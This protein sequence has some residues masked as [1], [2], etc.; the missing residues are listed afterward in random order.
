MSEM[1]DGLNVLFEDSVRR[2]RGTANTIENDCVIPVVQAATRF[3][4]AN[5]VIFTFLAFFGFFSAIPFL[6]A[7]AISTFA[8]TIL[9]A[10]LLGIFAFFTTGMLL[11][12]GV[13]LTPILAFTAFISF[14]ATSF[15]IGSFL[16]TRLYLCISKRGFSDI[17][18]GIM[19]WIGEMRLRVLLAFGLASSNEDAFF[20]TPEIAEEEETVIITQIAVPPTAESETD[21]RDEDKKTELEDRESSERVKLEIIDF[22]PVTTALDQ[23]EELKT[24]HKHSSKAAT[25]SPHKAIPKAK[26]EESPAEARSNLAHKD[27][28][29]T[30]A[31]EAGL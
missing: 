23:K 29:T 20:E 19:E 11:I 2:V 22:V 27:K 17:P 4:T 28:E 7:I 9:I 1:R 6:I 26:R 31:Q 5:P 15:L 10:V 25:Q 14:L 8:T 13:I 3:A 30:V 21:V 16:A 12:T 24:G 18:G